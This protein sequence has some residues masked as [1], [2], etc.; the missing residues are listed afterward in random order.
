MVGW[1]GVV[2]T[3]SDT[4]SNVLF[5]NLQTITAQTVGIAPMLAAAANTVGGVMGKM[6][7]A[8]SIVV[9]TAASGHVG[10]EGAILR[11]VFWHSVALVVLVGV[12]TAVMAGMGE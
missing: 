4:S 10:K 12:M 6:I 11:R 1:I 7:N 3:G 8:Q 2:L 5:G 9:A